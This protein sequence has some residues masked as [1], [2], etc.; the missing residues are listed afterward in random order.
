MTVTLDLAGLHGS[1][2]DPLLDSMN[3][4]N[5]IV[6]RHPDAISFAPGRPYDA[7]LDT[8]AITQALDAYTEY[9]AEERLFTKEQIARQLMQYG[10]TNGIIRDLIARAVALDEGIKAP[11]EAFVITAGCQEGMLLVLRALFAD[12]GDVLLVASP[13]YVGITGAARLLD[14]AVEP[15]L[16]GEHGLAPEAVAAA[17]QR[18]RA[19]G[20]RPRALYLV[21]DFSN[22]SGVNLPA[23]A[24]QALLDVAAE[25]DLLILED[26][27]YNF[28]YS[29]E[30]DPR[31]TMKSLDREG[32]VVYLG[33]TAKSAFPG[34]R[35]G[36]VL[37]D[38]SVR[39]ADGST[40]L[41]ADELSKIKSMTTVNTSPIA[42][43]V[44][45]GILVRNGGGLRAAA[46][47]AAAFYRENLA[48]LLASLAKHFRPEPGGV[49]GVGWNHP[50]GGFFVVVTVPFA[51]DT[52]ALERAAAEFKILWTP[53][54]DFYLGDGGA[55]QLRLS[56]SAV[57][58]DQV[59]EGVRRLAAFV[60]AQ[61][62]DAGAADATG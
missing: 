44:I 17:A 8:S 46:E 24:R 45:G 57:P 3:F 27:P 47:P 49:A 48:R 14:L 23:R 26:N 30:G 42:Q 29:Y 39:R 32:R 4:L 50:E 38:Q 28:F 16:E 31:P 25:Q 22:P 9:L 53:M 51:A 56:C 35:I 41:L 37:A 19:Q 54:S 52:A 12:P 55:R 11:P 40:T 58:A 36:Y 61:A 13:C 62:A 1:L 18:I 20:R 21:P 10:P 43:A 6:A 33:S 15:V 5:E 59:D 34:A 2:S 7:L 60:A